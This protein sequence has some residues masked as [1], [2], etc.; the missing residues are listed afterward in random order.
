MM[1]RQAPLVQVG[2]CLLRRL[3]VLAQSEHARFKQALEA[4]LALICKTEQC[5]PTS[6]MTRGINMST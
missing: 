4:V 2:S 5:N 6:V 3:G 1:E